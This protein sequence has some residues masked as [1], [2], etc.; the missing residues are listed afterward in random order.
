MDK[1]AGIIDHSP[2]WAMKSTAASAAITLR[3]CLILHF[4]IIP[5]AISSIF[6]T[7][8]HEM[9]HANKKREGA[10]KAAKG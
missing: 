10:P 1:H 6:H 7:G 5:C 9:I 3:L 2:A 4:A 8:V